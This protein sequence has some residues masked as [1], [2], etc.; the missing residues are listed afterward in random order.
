MLFDEF[1]PLAIKLLRFYIT[2]NSV[3]RI[4]F[5]TRYIKI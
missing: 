2:L 3:Q 4:S 5:R 1:F